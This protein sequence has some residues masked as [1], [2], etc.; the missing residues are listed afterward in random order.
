MACA[1]EN[2]NVH[3]D[4]DYLVVGAGA[5]GMV[6]VD[7]MLSENPSVN[8]V[9]VDR[10]EKPGGHWTL[11]YD[12]VTLHQPA[13]YYGV[14][15]TVL[16]GGK[17]HSHL[18]T[19]SEILDHFDDVLRRWLDTGRLRYFPSSSY[20]DDGSIVPLEGNSCPRYVVHP[21]MKTV[22]TTYSQVEVPAMRP[23]PYDVGGSAQVVIPG[24]LPCL[25]EQLPHRNNFVIVGG[26][27]T[28]IDTALWLLKEGVMASDIWWILPCDAWLY[29]RAIFQPG[30][31]HEMLTTF[32]RETSCATSVDD[33]YARLERAGHLLRLD[34]SVTPGRNRCASVSRDEL[35]K[36]RTLLPNVVRK[37]HVSSVIDGEITFES[38]ETWSF[39]SGSLLVDCTANGQPPRLPVPVF[40][41]KIITTQ[42]V[43]F[44]QTVFSATLI[45]HLEALY[46]D[47]EAWKNSLCTPVIMPHTPEDLILGMYQTLKNS[48]AWQRWPPLVLW[49]FKARSFELSV[50]HTPFWK[51]LKYRS[52]VMFTEPRAVKVLERLLERSRDSSAPAVQKAA[53]RDS[54]ASRRWPCVRG[55]STIMFLVIAA[56]I[57]KDA[58][59]LVVAQE[60]MLRNSS[61]T[62]S[63]TR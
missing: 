16:C 63:T 2:A 7:T 19:K 15:S 51:V 61:S 13:A 39:P 45:A 4:C 8:V 27:K 31:F 18:A 41:D 58:T 37:G 33:L 14:N 59:K 1:D 47:N 34:A 44:C 57:L 32:A 9:L 30:C 12:F 23:P 46:P 29:D 50:W 62:F 35:E 3:L 6:F 40:Q 55:P 26:G 11:A 36:L 21:R 53:P 5:T 25:C 56:Y 43:S 49:M 20:L 24:Q 52:H 42:N 17:D 10:Y 54:S 38:G 48:Q 60:R 22:D 28:G